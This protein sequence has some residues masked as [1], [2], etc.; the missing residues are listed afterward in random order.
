[1]VGRQ[2]VGKADQKDQTSR[3]QCRERDVTF[4]TE[5][6]SRRFINY[7]A[8][9][10]GTHKLRISVIYIYIYINYGQLARY[11][12]TTELAFVLEDEL[13]STLITVHCTHLSNRDIENTVICSNFH[14]SLRFNSIRFCMFSVV[15]FQF[16]MSLA[17]CL[18]RYVSCMSTLGA[19]KW[20]V[21]S[22]DF[23]IKLQQQYC[24][25]TSVFSM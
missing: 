14:L 13:R 12:S 25:N 6:E 2:G 17:F 20:S 4:M 9:I 23:I 21:V 8:Y 11:Y 3:D 22:S 24:A 18:L 5:T 16:C 10:T 7:I 1:M 19:C 15:V